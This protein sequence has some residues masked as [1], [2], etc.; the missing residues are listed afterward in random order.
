MTKKFTK[1]ALSYLNY[2]IDRKKTNLSNF[3]ASR[4]NFMKKIDSLGKSAN[5][6]RIKAISGNK[7]SK[8]SFMDNIRFRGQGFT[9]IRGA[10]LDVAHNDLKEGAKA[11]RK[12]KKQ[13]KNLTTGR[14]RFI[15]RHGKI[16]PIRS[17]K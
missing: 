11:L 16:I 14:V 10:A 2:V 7:L 15:R 13:R 17:K 12:L 4:L 1:S 6:T 3:K 5:E 9:G 8:K